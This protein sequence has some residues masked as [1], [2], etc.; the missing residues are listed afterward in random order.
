MGGYPSA[1]GPWWSRPAAGFLE[2]ENA[3]FRALKAAAPGSLLAMLAV[4][5][6]VGLLAGCGEAGPEGPPAD[7]NG[8][9]VRVSGMT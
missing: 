7:W 3:M 1:C 6:G 5:L 4:A 9:V 2:R 8:Y